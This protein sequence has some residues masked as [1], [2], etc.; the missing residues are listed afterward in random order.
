[1]Q[2]PDIQALYTHRHALYNAMISFVGHE[3]MLTKYFQG[4][5][6]PNN[7][8][9][10]DAGCGAGALTRAVCN[11]LTQQEKTAERI[12]GFDFSA[13]ALHDYATFGDHHPEHHIAGIHCDAQRID[14]DLPSDWKN[15]DLILSSGMLEYL[16]VTDLVNVLQKLA[17]RLSDNGRIIIFISRNTWLNRFLLEKIWKANTYTKT[18]LQSIFKHANLDIQKLK[19]FR[20]WGFVVEAT[21]A[22]G[23]N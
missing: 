7:V 23:Q 20:T 8:K 22:R 6:F 4:I 11:V 21:Y 13:R 19:P 3:T 2:K 15:Y 16:P 17:V 14:D 12:H 10:L 18:E 9:I 5:I 1:M